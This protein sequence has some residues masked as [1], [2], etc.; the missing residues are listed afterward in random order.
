ME[1]DIA[2]LPGILFCGLFII[3]GGLLLYGT[4]RRWPMLVNP[5]RKSRF[6]YSQTALRAL[7]GERGVVLCT[8]AMGVLFIAFAALGLWNGFR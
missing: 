6:I 5:P 1:A 8:Y 3:A 4:Y 7:L 2:K